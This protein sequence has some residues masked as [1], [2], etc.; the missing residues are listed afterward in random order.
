[1]IGAVVT[2]HLGDHF[3]AQAVRK[4]AA[5]ARATFERMPGLRSK[6]FT[7]NAGT[8]EA[9]NFYIWDSEEDAR[10]FF[11][12]ERLERVAGLYGARPRIEFV[13]IASLVENMRP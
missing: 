10:A 13:E 9:A 8:R 4:I 1:M 2:F 12:H 3:D 11:T 5:A 6:V 7:L